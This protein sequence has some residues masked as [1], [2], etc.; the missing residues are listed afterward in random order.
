M[1]GHKR[2]PV[3]F[4]RI[5]CTDG[6]EWWWLVSDGVAEPEAQLDGVE[7][8]DL[9]EELLAVHAAPDSEQTIER[10]MGFACSAVGCDDAGVLMVHSR[11]RVET[12]A[13]TSDP[14]ARAHDL[15]VE[16]DEGPC[17][18]AIE[19]PTGVYMI[20]DVA[21][22][23]RWPRWGAAVVELG[24]HSVISVPIATTA[25][26]YGSLNVYAKKPHAFDDDDLAVTLVVARH[27]S[28]AL[29]ATRDLE[30]LRKAIDA[31][32]LIGIAMGILMERYDV[33]SEKAFA[34]LRR[35][36][37]HHNVKLREVAALVA[38]RR[39]LPRSD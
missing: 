37:Q 27:A 21:I 20:S 23:D 22:D 36:S 1:A 3:R 39:R 12:A 2:V 5:S 9:T 26:R 25:R 15:Q 24:Y 14:V 4:G 31:R 19:D 33:D 17:L 38:E 7:P 30:G 11:S 35:Y 34:I 10:M 16:L 28:V 29:A 18:D 32:K 8:P 6:K 13:A